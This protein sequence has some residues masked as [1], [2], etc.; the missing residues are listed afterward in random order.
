[1][2][3]S[4]K[5]KIVFVHIPKTGGTSIEY[6]LDIHR[7]NQNIG[8][9]PYLKQKWDYNHLFG[10]GL[11]HLTLK[12]IEDFYSTCNFKSYVKFGRI[13]YII[14][15]LLK[16]NPLVEQEYKSKSFKEVK[17][18]Y[19][20]SIVR[21][22]YDRIVSYFAWL[23]GK[24]HK[25]IKLNKNDFKSYIDEVYK[26]G[27]FRINRHLLPQHEFIYNTKHFS[28]DKIIHFENLND[29]F[30]TIGKKLNLK[31]KLPKRMISF[32]EEFQFYYDDDSKQKVFDMYQKDFDLFN[33]SQ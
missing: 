30:A 31:C 15:H 17:S 10:K 16:L 1:M 24:W 25:N 19:K 7:D 20:F 32:H 14:D 11:Q 8:L 6:N 3:V 26:N 22:P 12:E 27:D 13:K 5:H 21:N 4:H 28:I 9:S 23:N 2:P 29:E 18:Y 33:Y